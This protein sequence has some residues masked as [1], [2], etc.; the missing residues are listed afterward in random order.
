VAEFVCGVREKNPNYLSACK[1]LRQ[2]QD[3]GY[4]VLHFPGEEKKEDFEQ[5]KKEKLE[6]EDYDFSG[7]VF[8]EGTSDFKGFEFEASVSFEGAQ[9]SGESTYFQRAQFSGEGT[10]FDQAK[11]SGRLTDFSEAQFSGAGTS[12]QE[13]KFAQEVSFREATFRERV[14]F[15]ESMA[16][17]VFDPQACAEFHDSRIEKPELLTFNT[18]LL[19][20]GWFINADMRKVDFTDVKWYGMPGGPQGNIEAEVKALED[21]EV[22]SP[23]TLLSQACRRLSANAEENPEYPLANEFYYWSMNALRKEGWRSLGGVVWEQ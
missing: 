20:P 8:P 10:F 14:A 23:Y 4:C 9:F 3:T 11:F 22:E 13:A 1:N 15:W 12:F 17:H 6:Q 18:V 19:H 21:R 7:T 2:Y 16:N 5:V